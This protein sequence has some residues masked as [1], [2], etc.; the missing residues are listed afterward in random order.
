MSEF[1][2]SPV[3]S[4]FQRTKNKVPPIFFTKYDAPRP[5]VHYCRTGNVRGLP[6]IPFR[7]HDIFADWDLNIDNLICFLSK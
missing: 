4:H 6:K 3:D 5:K 1:V 2:P 7:G